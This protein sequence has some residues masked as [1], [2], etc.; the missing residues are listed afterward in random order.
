MRISISVT[1]YDGVDLRDT[2]RA[3]DE[4]GVHTVWVTDHLIQA[5]PNASPDG[6]MLEAYT[7]LGF[8]AA[9]S[10]RVRGLA[11]WSAPSPSASPRCWSRR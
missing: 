4:A 8:L 1:N 10:G 2:V 3:A 11:P 7:T 9:V 5:D 6:A